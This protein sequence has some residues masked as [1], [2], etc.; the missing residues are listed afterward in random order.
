MSIYYDVVAINTGGSSEITVEYD[1]A[2]NT[3]I[4]SGLGAGSGA[5]YSETGPED[6]WHGYLELIL[7]RPEN[8]N[9]VSSAN[10]GF[11][12]PSGWDYATIY[13]DIQ[14]G[15]VNLGTLD[16][17]YGDNIRWKN[18]HRAGLVIF[19]K[20]KF[21]SK[22]KNINGIYVVD[23]YSSEFEGSRNQEAFFQYFE[24]LCNSIGTL[25]INK[26]LTFYPAVSSNEV[27]YYRVYQAAPYGLEH[28]LMGEFYGAG[29]DIGV[30][31][32]NSLSQV[33][34]WDFNGFDNETHYTF[35]MHGIVRPWIFLFLQC[36]EDVLP[37]F[38]GGFGTYYE[39]MCVAQRYGLDQVVE[40][41]FKPM[42]QYYIDNG[43]L[44]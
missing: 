38:K 44:T 40:R 30:D 23:V 19:N 37:W 33:Q 43:L 12:L 27:T 25:P 35:S 31:G 3:E 39:N 14:W 42:Y 1:V 21:N 26:H 36:T 10:L 8:H 34:L 6:F 2:S 9:E 15:Q 22:A 32:G 28:G 41:R 29:G 5:F 11:T 4:Y 13:S 20:S 24:Y 16:Y 18:F 7:F 17:M